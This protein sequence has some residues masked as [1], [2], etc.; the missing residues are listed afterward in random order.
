MSDKENG[1]PTGTDDLARREKGRE[2]LKKIGWGENYDGGERLG[3]VFWNYT[4]ENCFG[5]VWT[6]PGLSLRERELVTLG[7]LIAADSDGILPHMRNAC[8]LGVTEAEMREIIFQAMT[9]AGWPKGSAATKRF[10]AILEEPDCRYVRDPAA[11]KS[12]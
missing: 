3:D 9:Y 1:N 5:Q 7:V 10:N 4:L 2:T 11:Q 8:T 6:R 12:K